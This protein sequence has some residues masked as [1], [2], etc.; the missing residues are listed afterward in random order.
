MV[1]AAIILWELLDCLNKSPVL[2]LISLCS[3]PDRTM[4]M[5]FF[6][7]NQVISLLG[8]K[9]IFSSLCTYSFYLRYHGSF[10]CCP[11][12]SQQVAY[13]GPASSL[14]P[15]S[16]TSGSG[17][18]V[19]F[20]S[21]RSCSQSSLHKVFLKLPTWR[22]SVLHITLHPIVP[23]SLHLSFYFPMRSLFGVPSPHIPA[24]VQLLNTGMLSMLFYLSVFRAK[25]DVWSTGNVHKYFWMNVENY[26]LYLAEL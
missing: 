21:F 19:P 15:L 26:C 13:L 18:A 4:G 20:S 6:H 2:V 1:Q 11:P 8:G 10:L 22:A 17:M 7:W 3:I 14:A 24:Q 12:A 23:F 5:Y 25:H 9:G 16:S